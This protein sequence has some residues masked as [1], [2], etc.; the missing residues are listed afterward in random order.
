MGRDRKE[1]TMS[2]GHMLNSDV[3]AVLFFCSL[4]AIPYTAKKTGS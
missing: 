3:A 1:P 2:Q 4:T